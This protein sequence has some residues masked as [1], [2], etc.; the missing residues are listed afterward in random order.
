PNGQEVGGERYAYKLEW[1]RRLRRHLDATHTAGTP[2]ALLGYM[3]VA[4]SD[5]DVFDVVATRGQLLATDLERQAFT[6]LCSFGLTD[7][8]RHL[9]PTAKRFTWWDYRAGG[10]ERNLGLRIDRVLLSKPPLERL[11]SV[12][13]DEAER[14]KPQ[15]S[16][17]VP[18][19][20]EL[21]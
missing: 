18:I 3:N 19:M 7:A 9:E 5:R 13:M 2:L 17:H 1:F 21:R 11:V 15:P 12:H 14:G 8:V 4:P 20:I 16:D 10:W 6:E